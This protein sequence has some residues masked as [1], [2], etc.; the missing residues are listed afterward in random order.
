MP[1]VPAWQIDLALNKLEGMAIEPNMRIPTQASS[2]I[3][4]FGAKDD[5][6]NAHPRGL[7]TPNPPPARVAPATST[8]SLC[9]GRETAD[10]VVDLDDGRP[11]LSAHRASGIGVRA[12]IIDD[13]ALE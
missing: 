13:D 3:D 2:E 1:P 7:R 4:A 10:G 8:A 9:D 5:R 12:F 6:E 11:I